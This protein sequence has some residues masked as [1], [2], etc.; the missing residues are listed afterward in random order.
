LVLKREI[1]NNIESFVYDNSKAQKELGW[2]PEY[3]F[4]DML[5]DYKK[6]MSSRRFEYLLKKR[7]RM[8]KEG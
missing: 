5:K 7:E 4:K 1:P 3:S 2:K 8:I 6:E